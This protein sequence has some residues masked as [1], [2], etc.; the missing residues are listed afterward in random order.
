MALVSQAM[1]IRA[2]Y[3]IFSRSQCFASDASPVVRLDATDR[4]LHGRCLDRHVRIFRRF[5]PGSTSRRIFV[6]RR[7][8]GEGGLWTHA[9]SVRV[10]SR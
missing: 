3:P 9:S 5:A 8:V 7:V 2:S 1:S 10:P 4:T 6:L